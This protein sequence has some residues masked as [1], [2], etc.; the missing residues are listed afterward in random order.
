MAKKLSDWDL[1]LLDSLAQYGVRNLSYVANNL[2]IHPGTLYKRLKRLSSRFFLRFH[3]NIYHTN[4]G[5]KKAVVFADAVP[6]YEDLVFECLKAHDFWI[7]ISRCYGKFEGCFAIYTIPADYCNEFEK[8]L[9]ELKESNLVRNIE[10]CWSTC[11]QMVQS[12]RKWFDPLKKTWNFPWDFWIKEIFEEQVKLP[13][14]L[15]DPEDF[16]VTCDEIDLFILKELEKDATKDFTEIA[17]LFGTSQQLIG[18]HYNRHIIPRRL[19]ESFDITFM[20]FDPTVSDVFYFVFRFDSHEKL[21]KFA[22]SLLDKPFVFGVG[23]FL[24]QN[25]LIAHL[26]LPRNEFRNFVEALSQLARKRFLQ[27]YDYVI[28]DLDKAM[29]Q[30]IPY[31]FF[32]DRRWIYDHEKHVKNLKRLVQK[33]QRSKTKKKTQVF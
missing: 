25:S 12:R 6:G 16:P 28:L 30:T 27:S 32:K 3:I 2:G 10:V 14:T 11:F 18:Y 26:Y 22:N 19:I 7:Y 24:G 15:T 33:A 1:T 23:K 29:R 8:F 31:E 13:Y 21:A 20:H 4:L 17:K 5:L 9:E